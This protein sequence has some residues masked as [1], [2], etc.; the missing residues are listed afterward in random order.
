M[1]KNDKCPL[2]R[3]FF[4]YVEKKKPSEIGTV[5]EKCYNDQVLAAESLEKGSF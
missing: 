2:C 4:I 5:H 1:P 3:K